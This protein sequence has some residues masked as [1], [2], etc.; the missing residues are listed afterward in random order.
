[1]DTFERLVTGMSDDERQKLLKQ[2][3]TISDEETT[4]SSSPLTEDEPEL[5]ITAKLKEEHLLLRLWLFLKKIFSNTP[6]E[7]SY[8]TYL[9]DGIL[10]TIG[11]TSPDLYDY[12]NNYL[13]EGFLNYINELQQVIGFFR[14]SVKFAEDNRGN[15]FVFLGSLIMKNVNEQIASDVDPF[16]LPK[17]AI[18]SPEQRNSLI[19]KLDVILQEV[20]VS[21]KERM[22]A[23][24]QTM[25]WMKSF[26]HLPVDKFASRFAAPGN[27]RPS[28][29]LNTV[30]D[31]LEN[32]AQVLCSARKIQPIL[33]EARYMF[34]VQTRLE[35]EDFDIEAE[36]EGFMSSA[37]EQIALIRMFIS[38]IPLKKL[39]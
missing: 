15:F 9:V 23:A 39:T 12:K 8:N 34:S 14:E 19:R 28:A 6:V 3:A 37:K 32:F 30:S 38:S 7:V 2:C 29:P 22:Y 36:T 33:I 1:M 10:K 21:E 35:E 5:D 16:R 24:V 20:P 4:L 26:V 18:A 31:E 25:E 11:K 27:A 17:D 13:L